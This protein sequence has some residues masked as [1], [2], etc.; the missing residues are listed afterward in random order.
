MKFNLR[1][2]PIAQ[3]FPQQFLLQ[4]LELELSAGTGEST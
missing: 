4:E 3:S 1:A 2:E